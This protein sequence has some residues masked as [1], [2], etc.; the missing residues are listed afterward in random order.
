MLGAVHLACVKDANYQRSPCV[1]DAVHLGSSI[2]R[3]WRRLCVHCCP[4][5]SSSRGWSQLPENS[6]G[7]Q[8]A[9]RDSQ[10]CSPNSLCRWSSAGANA[11]PVLK[12]LH[13]DTNLLQ[14]TLPISWGAGGSFAS[15]ANI[16]LA[17]NDLSGS[18]PMGWGVDANGDS[19]F[20]TLQAVTLRPGTPSHLAF[21]VNEYRP[22]ATVH[23]PNQHV[24]LMHASC[25]ISSGSCGTCGVSLAVLTSSSMFCSQ[26]A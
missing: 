10:F 21:L 7:S 8:G 22:K 18:V 20:R 14:G 17:G 2:S 1:P 5:H 4:W 11:W 12:E 15:L 19:N 9:K 3:H 6:Q 26:T 25:R 13:L 24:A 16:T 23:A